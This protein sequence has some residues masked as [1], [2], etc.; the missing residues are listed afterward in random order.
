M[1]PSSSVTG[2]SCTPSTEMP[3]LRGAASFQQ[4]LISLALL[5]DL[6]RSKESRTH[7]VAQDSRP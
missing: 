5:A 3:P 2:V 6:P 4:R 1:V 7:A